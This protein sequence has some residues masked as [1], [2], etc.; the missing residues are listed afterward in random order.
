[1]YYPGNMGQASIKTTYLQSPIYDTTDLELDSLDP[2]FN[3]TFYCNS[4]PSVISLTPKIPTLS[5]ETSNKTYNTATKIIQG[6]N[7]PEYGCRD[8]KMREK[9]KHFCFCDG[10]R[11]KSANGN[12]KN[13]FFIIKFCFILFAMNFL[14]SFL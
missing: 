5:G 4:T 8:I 1:M 9:V 3:F 12:L 7:K 13:N 6:T 10:D 11:C 2:F 14:L